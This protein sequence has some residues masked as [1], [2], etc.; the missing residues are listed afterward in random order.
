MALERASGPGLRI[1]GHIAARQSCD[2]E[3]G[4]SRAPWAHT[5]RGTAKCQRRGQGGYRRDPGGWGVNGRGASL[6]PPVP[7]LCSPAKCPLRGG[8]PDPSSDGCSGLSQPYTARK[9]LPDLPSK[10]QGW[11]RGGAGGEERD[12]ARGGE[13]PACASAVFTAPGFSSSPATT[14][15]FPPGGPLLE[16]VQQ[17][18]SPCRSPGGAETRLTPV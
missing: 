18:P 5:M 3:A 15:H 9:R 2:G 17:P 1:S 14:A 12:M 8:C 4:S 16:V 11:G 10:S 13:T 7:P 6:R